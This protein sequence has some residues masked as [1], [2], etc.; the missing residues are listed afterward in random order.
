MTLPRPR[1]H[2]LE[3]LAALEES[4]VDG[5]RAQLVMACGAG[6]TLVGRWLAQRREAAITLVVVPS[7][8]LVAQTLAEW[9][10]AGDWAFEALITCSD[11]STAAGAAERA[12]ADDQD[13][14]APF[15][16]SH[17][18]KV[19]TRPGVVASTLRGR[20]A[21]RPLVIFSTYH[22][23]HVVAAA[24]VSAG[25]VLDLVVAD[26]AHNL[27]GHPRTEFRVV[28]SQALPAR[29]RV[30][31]TATQ[32]VARATES[33]AGFDD[34]SH[35]LSM[36]DVAL[37]GP[38]AYRLNFAEA[39]A[40][41]L[42]ADYQVLI[43]ETPGE[44][45]PSPVSALLTAAAEGLTSVL[46]FH[47]RVAK[48]R[49]FADSVNGMRLP[50]GRTV[51]ALS[52]AGSD[53]T[54]QR[55]QALELLANAAADQL[56]VVSS[57]R[58]LTEGVDIPA[59]DGVLFADPKHSDVDVVQ[60]VG[61]ALRKSEGKRSGLV[62]IPVCLP[63]DL[64]EDT[65]LSTSAFAAV[66]RI[67][68]G[69][70]TLDARLAGELDSFA[71]TPS[72]RGTDDGSQLSRIRFSMPSFGDTHRLVAKVVDFTS[73]AWEKT[74]DELG[75]FTFEHG[76]ARPPA[77]T[78]LG[79]WCERQR[80]SHR[81]G[82]LLPERV[83]RLRS[84]PG[85]S[86]DLTGHRWTE[87]WAH[88]LRVAHAAGRLDV[89][90]PET[91][92]VRLVRR[93]PRSP[94]A[95]IG[96]W[97]A[98]QRQLARRGELDDWRRAKLEEILGWS[99]SALTPLDQA[100]VDLLAEYVA[101]KGTANPPTDYVDDDLAVGSWLNDVRRRRATER[102]TQSLLDEL[103]IV[104]PSSVTNG[105]L[106]W[107]R[108]ETL[109]LLGLEALRQF[110][111][112]EGHCRVPDQH[113]EP[114]P[115]LDAQLSVWCRRQ[116]HSHRYGN[117]G[118]S[119]AC[120]LEAIPGWRWEIQPAP[121]VHLDIGDSRHGTRTGYVKGCRCDPCTEAN[122]ADHQARTARA[123]AGGPTTDLVS[124]ARAC[125]HL[126]I[127]AGQGAQLKPLA[128]ACG[129][130]VKTVEEITKGERSR[131]LPS[132]ERILLEVTLADVRAA[133]NPG[134]RVEAAPTWALLDDMVARGWP[135]S[136]IARELGLGAALQLSHSSLSAEN[137]AK[138]ADLDRR[139]GQL[140]APPRSFRAPTS[141]VHEL[142]SDL[143]QSA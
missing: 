56:V 62:M 51:V 126:R 77:G 125:G 98:R 12:S 133:A 42:L 16:A 17:R 1:P 80:T 110:V 40:A 104:C 4:L 3:A 100:C 75:A 76:H 102:L 22:S 106:R 86:W 69:L 46:S 30:F 58:C 9:R 68:R 81:A 13:V 118:S 54:A 61:R 50:D 6:K 116:R 97:C 39:I 124:A 65:A 120:L 109:W 64:D 114:L 72:R 27:S 90:D 41:D 96:R 37:F 36:D 71:R 140:S 117:L 5:D 57:A 115:D 7:L 14:A 8:A 128:R 66:W 20:P 95:S 129:L 87:Q 94:I 82:M 84:L 105:A 33:A 122:L 15:W 19:T 79:G 28:L 34:W 11:P 59:V 32:V 127:L 73:P 10:S 52:V 24:A 123:A 111:D 93:E 44:V 89:N 101:W 137:A 63:P 142:L 141:P 138:V 108:G 119:R 70:R 35:P 60:A 136:W 143:E 29:A 132:T 83:A 31:M 74:F 130:N 2:Q 38:V 131:I 85:W 49:A 135:K 78:R 92:G 112:R 48:A 121:R 139:L 103:D 91:M 88:T 134:T 55:A 45:T 113:I 25:V 53:P 107:Y 43:F 18:A 47:G 21:A 67:L 26:E 99:W 23:A